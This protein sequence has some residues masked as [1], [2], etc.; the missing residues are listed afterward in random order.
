MNLLFTAGDY[1]LERWR[2]ACYLAA[3]TTAVLVFGLRR[4][5]WPRSVRHAFARE[6]HSMGVEAFPLAGLG[7]IVLGVVVVIVSARL[8]GGLIKP[9]LLEP[10]LVLVVAR[11]L[12]PLFTNIVIIARNG[13]ATTAELALSKTS[14]EVKRLEEQ[15]VDPLIALVLPRVLGAA[16]AVACLTMIF[17]AISFATAFAIGVVTE[18]VQVNVHRY[19]DG[20]LESMTPAVM[21]AIAAKSVLPAL[22]CS[23]ICSTQGLAVKSMAEVP[24][25]TRR[26]MFRSLTVLFVV[27]ASLALLI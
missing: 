14:G 13:S 7:A 10:L 9:D 25:A 5:S 20:L 11:E 23:V 8:G 2:D 3:V 16:V 22:A 21:L 6:L 26:A 19:L 24:A 17:V 27:S 4:R 18:H 15:G 1:V 12:G